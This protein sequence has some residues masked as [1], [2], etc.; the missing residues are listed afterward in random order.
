M[1]L[2]H[3]EV[4]KISR[5]LQNFSDKFLGREQKKIEN[6]CYEQYVCTKIIQEAFM[7][8]S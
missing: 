4:R 2:I 3:L 8:F 6:P 7:N 5:G 1:V